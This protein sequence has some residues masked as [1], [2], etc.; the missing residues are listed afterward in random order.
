[1]VQEGR[2][3]KSGSLVIKTRQISMTQVKQGVTKGRKGGYS[4][5]T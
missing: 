5:S 4:V 1:M 2:K 3:L